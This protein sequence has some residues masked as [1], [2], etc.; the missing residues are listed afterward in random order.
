MS[1][2]EQLKQGGIDSL[3]IDRRQFMANALALAAISIVAHAAPEMK[4][5]PHCLHTAGVITAW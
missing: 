2:S 4:V 3:G 1:E 5:N